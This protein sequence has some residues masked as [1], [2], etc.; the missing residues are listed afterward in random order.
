MVLQ[1]VADKKQMVNNGGALT[2]ADP[3]GRMERYLNTIEAFS[4][5]SGLQLNLKK[6]CSMSIDFGRVNVNTD[7]IRLPLSNFVIPTTKC[8]KLLGVHIDDKLNWN[9]NVKARAK[10]GNAMVWF[11][12]R[13]K[14]NG[15]RNWH[16]T[17]VYKIYVIPSL[18]YCISPILKM[19]TDEQKKKLEK[20][21]RRMS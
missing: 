21:Q 3:D 16:L 20:T 10:A 18:E 14:A 13:L 9:E 6:C 4:V 5:E 7:N 19:L 1:F 11:L 8:M 2:F 15:V 12:K 17:R